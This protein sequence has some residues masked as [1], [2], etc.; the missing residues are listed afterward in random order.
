VPVKFLTHN[1]TKEFVE[2]SPFPLSIT[3][4]FRGFLDFVKEKIKK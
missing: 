4:G 1:G 3:D 2:H